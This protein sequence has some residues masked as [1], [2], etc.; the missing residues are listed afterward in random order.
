MAV[1]FQKHTRRAP[2]TSAAFFL[3]VIGMTLTQLFNLDDTTITWGFD[4]LQTNGKV[5]YW[6]PPSST[7]NPHVPTRPIIDRDENLWWRH[8]VE[9]ISNLRHPHLGARRRQHN[10]LNGNQD[11]SL[12]WVVDPSVERLQRRYDPLRRQDLPDFMC[13]DKTSSSSDNNDTNNASATLPRIEGEGGYRVLQNVR[14]GLDDARRTLETKTASSFSSPRILCMVYSVH[15]GNGD[16]YTNT[17]LNAIASTW[18]SHCDG[19][20]AFSNF[21]DHSVGAIDAV[22]AGDEEYG[23]SERKSFLGLASLLLERCLLTV[24]LLTTVW[25]KVRAMWTYAFD[26][27]VEEFD[28]FFMGG[29]D[30][31]LIVEQLRA[32][33]ISSEIQRHLYENNTSAAPP[34][35]LALGMPHLSQGMP[36]L[37]GGPGYL[38][39][40]AAVKVWGREGADFYLTNKTASHEDYLMGYFLWHQGRLL[41]PE[42]A[43]APDG[44]YRFGFSAEYTSRFVPSQRRCGQQRC[45]RVARKLG[46][47]VTA[48]KGSAWQISFHMKED[49]LIHAH[50]LKGNEFLTVQK[51]YTVGQRMLRYH[52]Y[53]NRWCD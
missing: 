6:N 17:N 18:A 8:Q 15:Y 24:S 38:L 19:Y 41:I 44:G 46:F 23:N 3:F 53:L 50:E 16:T 40:R 5:E 31:Y 34:R 51:Q 47:N 29:D 25:Q 49:S 14:R 33:L 22:H 21:T 13:P 35:P 37:Y 48:Q 45:A 43:V 11:Y 9:H 20:I 32:F 4:H 30:V 10:H 26:H 42:L 2:P 28:Y 27:Y 36:V 39:N 7:T 1:V 12:G 52:A